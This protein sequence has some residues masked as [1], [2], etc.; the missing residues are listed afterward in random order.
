MALLTPNKPSTHLQPSCGS[1]PR[2]NIRDHLSAQPIRLVARKRLLL[3]LSVPFFALIRPKPVSQSPR[4][5]RAYSS[6]GLYFL[7]FPLLL[8]ASAWHYSLRA[9]HVLSFNHL[10]RARRVPIS[11]GGEA[12]AGSVTFSDCRGRES[13]V[14][15]C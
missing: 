5:R 13:R 11:S 14:V 15:R 6:R 9:S 4:S 1:R 12:R 8:L 7:L 3:S 10:P 2:R